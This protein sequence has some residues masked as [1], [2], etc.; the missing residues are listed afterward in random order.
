MV[1][2]NSLMNT[3]SAMAIAASIDNMRQERLS[4]DRYLTLHQDRQALESGFTEFYKRN[5]VSD[6]TPDIIEKA[7]AAYKKDRFTYKGWSG[8]SWGKTLALSYLWFQP[9]WKKVSLTTAGGLLSCMVIIG[10][11]MLATDAIRAGVR[12]QAAASI[13]QD[14]GNFDAS[15]AGLSKEISNRQVWLNALTKNGAS[16]AIL[17]HQQ[18]AAVSDQLV[19]L[20]ELRDD[21][22][23]WAKTSMVAD[24]TLVE[25]DPVAAQAQWQAKTYP[26]M[27]AFRKDLGAARA[28]MA[29]RVAVVDALKETSERLAQIRESALFVSYASEPDV[30]FKLSRAEMDFSQGRVE[31]ARAG[32][33]QLG[34]LLQGRQNAKQLMVNVATLGAQVQPIFK[35]EA[36][37]TRLNRLMAQAQLAAQQGNKENYTRISDQI[38]ALADYVASPLHLEITTGPDGKSGIEREYHENGMANTPGPKRWYLVVRAIDASGNPH[39]MDIINVETQKTSRVSVW[40]Q[41]VS[42]KGY[43]AVKQD[44][45]ADGILDNTNVGDKASGFYDFD[46]S[47]PMLNGTLSLR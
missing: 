11:G 31:E 5:G 25:Q 30:A 22:S 21:I 4:L 13:Q 43:D 46:Y 41:E 24:Q 8:T 42:K 45:L 17:L 18:L 28:E 27:D 34:Q 9:R 14:V 20:I 47:M 26:P 37:R 2:S 23:A 7:V 3:A 38:S 29:K 35:D 1:M 44:K 32:V 16:S 19:V 33:D 36:G 15:L 12:H 6:V 40:A 39:P 10:G